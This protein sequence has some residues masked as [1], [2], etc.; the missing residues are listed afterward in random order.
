MPYRLLSLLLLPLL[1]LLPPS[2]QAGDNLLPVEEAFALNAS[3]G[4]RG[5]VDLHWDIAPDYYLYR[6]RIKLR[7]DDDQ[8]QLGEL[9]LPPGEQ[10]HDEFF[11]DVEIFH[12][13]LDAVLPYTGDV[14]EV[15]FTIT[16]QGCHE[17]EPQI[18]YPPHATKLTLQAPARDNSA[19]AAPM[20]APAVLPSGD[21][22]NLLGNRGGNPF[23]AAAGTAAGEPLPPEQA[24][25]FEAIASSPTEVL[26]RWSMPDNYYLYRDQTVLTV[27]GDAVQLGSPTW[28][29]GQQ[30]EDAW[31]GTTEVYFR[32]VELP[33]PLLRTDGEPQDLILNVEY[34]GCQD[35]GICYPVMNRSITLALPAADTTQ[36][37][38]AKAAFNPADTAG[39]AAVSEELAEDQQLMAKLSGNLALALLAFFGFGLLLAF[40]PCVF[41]MVPIL[42]GI[43]AG[44]GDITTRRAL[45]LSV[46]Y[47]LATSVVFTM[48]GVTAGLLGANLQAAFQKPWILWSFA[49]LFVLLSLSMFGFYELELPASWQNRLAGLSN[50]Q[51]A[52]SL[53]GVAVMGMLSALI[54]GPCVAPPL[55]AAVIYISQT[56]DPVLGGLALFSLSLGMGAPLVVFGT[57]AG[58]L[59]PRAGAWMNAVKAA[60]G[61]SFLALAIWML[62]RILDP[63][64]IMLMTGVLLI[65][66]GV[67]MGALLRPAQPLSGW[68]TLWQALGLIAL[69]LGAA[70]LV[71][72]AGGNRDVLQPLAGLGGGAGGTAR[73]ALQF[74]MIKSVDDLER[75]VT[76]ANAAGRTVMLDFYADWCVTCKEMERYTLSATQVQQALDGVHLLKADVTAN[77]KQDQQLLKHFE[78]FGPP[79]TIFYNTDGA[80]Q[81][82][83]RLIGFE[84]ADDFAG[85][86]TRARQ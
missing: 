80:E 82:N 50:R 76:A 31:F 48:A 41:P 44:A 16:V 15:S 68:R 20:A 38:S 53:T 75:E 56:R 78:L 71:G 24:F 8:A 7:S 45:L 9:Q 67:Y 26:A 13:R 37:A 27:D 83:L 74:N 3:I 55:A 34:Q 58:K 11:G 73:P 42:S 30:H 39:P 52:G 57:A 33:I 35:G 61:V 14:D 85:R 81:R 28:P 47:V 64:W 63:A 79:A 21:A 84:K 18:C 5:Q 25:V 54:V 59:M 10:T 51:K 43:I 77:D 46:V 32:S 23:G 66:S 36:L 72:V 6:G 29:K 86:V 65:A 49:V 60:F 17:A 62:S 70:Q 40:T 12:D 69:L 2:V 4:Q 22:F 19:A 1:A